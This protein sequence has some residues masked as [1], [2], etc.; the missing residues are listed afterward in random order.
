MTSPGILILGESDVELRDFV[1][2][3]TGRDHIAGRAV[4]WTLS[5]KYFTADLTVTLRTPAE[6]LHEAAVDHQAVVVVVA[7]AGAGATPPLARAQRLWSRVED[8]GAE[9]DV[10]LVVGLGG[11]PAEEWVATADAWFAARL[12][13]FVAV[14][15]GDGGGGGPIPLAEGGAEGMQRVVEALSSHMWPGMRRQP[16]AGC[17]GS[18][19]GGGGSA[20]QEALASPPDAFFSGEEEEGEGLGQVFTEIEREWDRAALDS[21]PLVPTRLT[22]TPRCDFPSVQSSAAG[23]AA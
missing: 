23:R 13:E 3:L 2:R 16:A 1:A 12:I 6:G 7:S 19:G 14:G 15:E 5:N 18:G 21:R 8:H 17:S 4:E 10:K 9:Y 11:A 22:P 20:A